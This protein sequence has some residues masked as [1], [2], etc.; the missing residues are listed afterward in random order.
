MGKKKIVLQCENVKYDDK[1]QNVLW[2]TVE[3]YTFVGTA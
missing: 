2:E 1:S 3:C